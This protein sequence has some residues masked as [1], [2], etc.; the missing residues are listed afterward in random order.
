MRSAEVHGPPT[1]SDP[2][3][4]IRPRTA[5]YGRF[6]PRDHP[7]RRS[8]SEPNADG[9]R[10]ISDH[11]V[12]GGDRCLPR[13]RGIPTPC[14]WLSS[15]T[16]LLGAPSTFPG[17]LSCH[18]RTSASASLCWAYARNTPRY[19]EQQQQPPLVHQT[20]VL[21]RQMSFLL[22]LL[23]SLAFVRSATAATAADWRSRSIYQCASDTMIMVKLL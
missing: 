4:P 19:P 23:S 22:L 18:P 9:R 12:T 7:A 14:L 17:P 11:A 5:N 3:V 1:R 16:V 13:L 20:S 21:S 15:T 2:H 8:C 10:R 6:G